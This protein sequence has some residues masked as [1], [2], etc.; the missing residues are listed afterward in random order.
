VKFFAAANVE[1]AFEDVPGLVI[2]VM[3]VPGSNE[4]RMAGRAAGI[5]PFGNDE[6]S[7]RATQDV[8]S[9]RRSKYPGGHGRLSIQDG[10]MR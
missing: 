1:K 6:G 5:T 10:V 8:A 4:T 2:L 7:V 3:D 9:Q